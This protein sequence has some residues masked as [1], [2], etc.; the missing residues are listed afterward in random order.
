MMLSGLWASPDFRELFIWTSVLYWAQVYRK[1]QTKLCR[2]QVK[3]WHHWDF[4]Q[5]ALWTGN[6][7]W[8]QVN[9]VG[10]QHWF[11]MF[12]KNYNFREDILHLRIHADEAAV[13]NLNQ[14]IAKHLNI[15]SANFYPNKVI[16]NKIREILAWSTWTLLLFRRILEHFG[17]IIWAI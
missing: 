7:H 5:S 2:S 11:K 4:W 8:V 10:T 6:C 12:L 14:I 3:S 1:A 16:S 17:I 13:R 15:T 9:Q